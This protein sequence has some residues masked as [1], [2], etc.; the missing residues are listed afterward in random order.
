MEVIDL[1]GRAFENHNIVVLLSE[2]IIVTIQVPIS[3]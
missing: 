3:H 2:T 1:Q